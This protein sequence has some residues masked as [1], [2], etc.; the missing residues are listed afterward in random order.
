[1]LK[2]DAPV[3][4]V[5]RMAAYGIAVELVRKV[6]SCSRQWNGWANL[7]DQARRAAVSALLN[8]AEGFEQPP[9]SDAKKRHYEIAVGSAG[10][11]SAA[12]DAALALELSDVALLKSARKDARTLGMLLR[13][14]VRSVKRH[15]M[16]SKRSQRASAPATELRS[17]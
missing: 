1:M 12:L 13:G 10:E 16:A 14:L 2:M 6:G 8:L 11:V 9:G 3:F 7:G 5:E 15:S 4:G 17:M